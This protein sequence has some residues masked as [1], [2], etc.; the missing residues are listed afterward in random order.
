MPDASCWVTLP[1]SSFAE[2]A[3]VSPVVADE[4]LSALV[5]IAA[6][7]PEPRRDGPRAR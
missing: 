3:M 6:V 1:A 7:V 2:L 4:V 5:V